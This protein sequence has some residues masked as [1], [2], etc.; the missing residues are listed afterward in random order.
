MDRRVFRL[1][2]LVCAILVCA[3]I[4]FSALFFPGRQANGDKAYSRF[5]RRASDVFDTEIML[6]GFAVSEE[7]FDR[8]SDE[9]IR[10]L[11]AYN[12][13][14]DGYNAYGDMHNL[15]YIN[16]HAAE[17]PV[18]IPDE[19]FDLLVWCRR[20]WDDGLSAVN[21]A[22]GAVLSIWHDY[23]TAGIEDPANAQLPPMEQLTA[24]NAHTDFAAVILDEK[25]KTVYYADP[26]LKI[27]VGA[28]AKGYAADLIRD[29]LMTEMPS[30]LLSLGGN[31]YAGEA[32]MDGRSAWA[33]AVQDPRADDL[34]ANANGS[35]R[36]DILDISSLSAV[37]SG[38]YWRFYIVDGQRYHHIIDP[39]T[40]M[41]SRS[42]QSV[43]IVCESSLLADYLST[44]LFIDSFEE[45][46]ALI[47]SMD[48][49]EA[50]W[51]L[52]DGSIRYSPGMG[53]YSRALKAGD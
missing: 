34:I 12:Q 45:G 7:A 31:V 38:D 36:L 11:T 15:Y 8:V 29:Y 51:V 47:A 20:K 37:T 23:R 49:V 5:T 35:N 22:M 16:Q 48:G 14:F 46:S 42:V 3:V 28:V 24:A 10:R 50:M 9:V 39:E 19:L 6:S 25:N 2:A 52:P 32:P 13:I 4:L 40:L 53:S 43:T 21:P 1:T 17:T 33:V 30:F 44:T 41:P 27:D 18:E 26:L